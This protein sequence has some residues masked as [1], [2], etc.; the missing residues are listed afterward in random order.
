MTIIGT[1]LSTKG[2]VG[3]TTTLANIAG[4]LCDLG[5]RVLLIDADVQPSLTR[6]YQLANRAKHGLTDL[7]QSGM[8][9]EDHISRIELRHPDSSIAPSEGCLD[10]VCS[11]V[12]DA[13]L[14]VW[15]SD[16]VDRS[17]RLKNALKS[18]VIDER[19]DV[20]L[21]DT[22]GAVGALQQT[23]VFASSFAFSPVSPDIISAREFASGTL[24]LLADLAPGE[25][26]GLPVPQLHVLICKLS[27]T[28]NAKQVAQHLRAEYRN[29]DGRKIPN[30]NMLDAFIPD[31]VAYCDAA[32]ARLPV[33]WIDPAKA[34]LKMHQLVWELFPSLQGFV[35]D[36]CEGAFAIEP[37][38][39]D[40]P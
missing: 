23:A 6:Y 18:P 38:E 15:L 2:G 14:E 30:I 17:F 40:T 3:K 5:V 28:R 9:T 36:A 12:P 25:R 13:S 39:G 34:G 35:A 7:I 31:A 32:T 22:Q 24:R 20:V 26:I 19:Y 8:V 37:E 21:I 27:R 29:Q 1:A 16:R 10:I 4:L 11:D 33:H